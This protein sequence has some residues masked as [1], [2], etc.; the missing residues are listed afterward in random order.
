MNV[1]VANKIVRPPKRRGFAKRMF[2]Q[3]PSSGLEGAVP[4]GENASPFSMQNRSSTVPDALCS[5]FF[6]ILSIFVH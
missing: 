2:I 3:S 1:M 4:A 5:L 6:G